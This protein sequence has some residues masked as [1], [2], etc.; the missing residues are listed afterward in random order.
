MTSREAH[1]PSARCARDRSRRPLPDTRQCASVTLFGFGW[2]DAAAARASRL[3]SNAVRRPAARI[4]LRSWP[5]LDTRNPP[6]QQPVPTRSTAAQVYY[7]P[8]D[9]RGKAGFGVYH[10]MDSEWAWLKSL[11]QQGLIQRAC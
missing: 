5:A 1:L 10:A 6:P 4:S 11:Q 3:A 2:C 7:D 9:L 8:H